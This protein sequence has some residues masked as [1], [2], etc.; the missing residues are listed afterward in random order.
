MTLFTPDRAYFRVERARLHRARE[1]DE[2]AIRDL[3]A[4]LAVASDAEASI[5][6]ADLL[7]NRGR[8]VQAET[9]LTSIPRPDQLS[10][11]LGL[12]VRNLLR[13]I[14]I[15]MAVTGLEQQERVLL[16][17]LPTLPEE[18][19]AEDVMPSLKRSMRCAPDSGICCQQSP[20][21]S[22]L[23]PTRRLWP[24]FAIRRAPK[25]GRTPLH[26]P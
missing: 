3:E 14:S 13:A 16:P 2:A 18:F 6:L 25:L 11:H 15:V 1:D 24:P 4:A 22:K 20:L 9:A 5:A 21:I 8:F 19:M 17:E 12:Q 10:S 26:S 23:R 7:L